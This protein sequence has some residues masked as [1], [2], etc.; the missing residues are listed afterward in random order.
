MVTPGDGLP[1]PSG[2]KKIKKKDKLAEIG[3]WL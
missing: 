1:K 2:L 3:L